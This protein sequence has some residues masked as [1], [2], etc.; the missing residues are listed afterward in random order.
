MKLNFLVAGLLGVAIAGISAVYADDWQNR[1]VF[2]ARGIVLFVPELISTEELRNLLFSAP[3]N[4]PRTRSVFKNKRQRKDGVLVS[5]S[6]A[7]PINFAY[8]ST[9]LTPDSKVRLNTL[10]DMR[11]VDNAVDKSLA[12]EGH[13]D[14]VGNKAYNIALSVRRAESVKQYLVFQLDISSDRLDIDGKG[15][16]EL[17]DPENPK[18][19]LNRR[20]QFAAS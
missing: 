14:V 4:K 8:N 2:T 17:I 9:D 6:V 7:M 11:N 1:S 15:E 12:I 18:G 20:V 19:R 13:A 5:V 10:D 3:T 16:G